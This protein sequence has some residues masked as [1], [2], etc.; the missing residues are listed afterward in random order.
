[1]HSLKTYSWKFLYHILGWISEGTLLNFLPFNA[2]ITNTPR[3]IRRGTHQVKFPLADHSKHEV[4][5]EKKS[6]VSNRKRD[7][8]ELFWL[9]LA[10]S[11]RYSHEGQNGK[12]EWCDLIF[13]LWQ[14][15]SVQI[16]CYTGEGKGTN[17]AP[18]LGYPTL[19]SVSPAPLSCRP[20]GK[21]MRSSAP[22][23]AAGALRESSTNT[24]APALLPLTWTAIPHNQEDTDPTKCPSAIRFHRHPVSYFTDVT[25]MGLYA[26]LA[27][28]SNTINWKKIY[29]SSVRGAAIYGV[30]IASTHYLSLGSGIPSCLLYLAVQICPQHLVCS[31]WTPHFL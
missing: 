10:V 2:G 4:F 27:S 14:T 24:S 29:M 15:S 12:K 26:V 6:D 18:A 9:N 11:K 1:M 23:P 28:I 25:L 5:Q 17:S 13:W 21:T 19:L 7:Y 8:M 3:R 16:L 31:R 20:Q 30:D 22:A